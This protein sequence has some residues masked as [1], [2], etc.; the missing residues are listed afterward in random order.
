VSDAYDNAKCVRLL[1]LPRAPVETP[2]PAVAADFAP[3]AHS[4][5]RAATGYRMHAARGLP[6][7]RMSHV[8]TRIYIV[9][10]NIHF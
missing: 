1:L 7:G 4:S 9:F 8:P 6:G 2:V 3:V 5:S 10:R